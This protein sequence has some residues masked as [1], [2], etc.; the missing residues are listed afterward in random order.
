MSDIFGANQTELVGVARAGRS[1]LRFRT[2]QVPGATTTHEPSVDDEFELVASGVNIFASENVEPVILPA[3][4]EP[5]GTNSPNEKARVL[6]IGDLGVGGLTLESYIGEGLDEFL[7]TGISLSERE[8]GGVTYAGIDNRPNLIVEMWNS[9][10]NTGGQMTSLEKNVKFTLSRWKITR[11]HMDNDFG[12]GAIPL[13]Q[14]GDATEGEEDPGAEGTANGITIFAL[15]VSME[16]EPLEDIDV[17][18]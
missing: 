5:D 18:A 12:Q 16:T 10:V 13:A 11:F 1:V 17:L 9:S 2:G 3:K 15:N 8:I 6:L 14:I 7:K 4:G